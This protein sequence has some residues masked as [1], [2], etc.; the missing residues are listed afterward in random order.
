MERDNT[1]ELQAYDMCARSVMSLETDERYMNNGILKY[2]ISCDT[3]KVLHK[4]PNVDVE[5]DL[6]KNN[7]LVQN[8]C[9]YGKYQGKNNARDQSGPWVSQFESGLYNRTVPVLFNENTK[10]YFNNEPYKKPY[11]IEPMKGDIYG[12]LM[13]Y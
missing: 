12:K 2:I 6:Q 8:I 3:T 9:Y 5:T 7:C 1:I 13:K 11:N 4:A 10:R